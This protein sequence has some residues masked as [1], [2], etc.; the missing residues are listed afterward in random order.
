M[1]SAGVVTAQLTADDDTVIVAL[2]SEADD[3]APIVDLTV[4][5]LAAHV[6][7]RP[8]PASAASTCPGSA[9]TTTSP[10]PTCSSAPIAD[11]RRRRRRGHVRRTRRRAD[12]DDHRRGRRRRPAPFS[13]S[14]RSRTLVGG[15]GDD[16]FQ[17]NGPLTGT[18]GSTAAAATTRWPGR[19]PVNH[20][21][22]HRRRRRHDQ[23]RHDVRGSIER[24]VGGS[25]AA[26]GSSSAPPAQI[27]GSID[28]GEIQ[29]DAGGPDDVNTLDFSRRGRRRH[30]RPRGRHG[31]RWHRRV[32][33]HQ[34]ARR[35]APAPA[36]RSRA[37][38]P[39]RPDGV[40]DHAANAGHVDGVAFAGFENLTGQAATN[41]AFIFAPAAASPA[42]SPAAPAALDGFA[43]VVGADLRRL[44]AGGRRR[45]QRRRH[46]V[47]GRH[48]HLHRHGSLRPVGGDR[49]RPGRQRL[50]LRPQ[51]PRSPCRRSADADVPDAGLHHHRAAP[52]QQLHVRRADG[53]AVA[54]HRHRRR[55]DHDDARPRPTR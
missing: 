4:N 45:A 36:T 48:R 11:L 27:T 1:Y 15:A 12:L 16:S 39:A 19:T 49:R 23:R 55:R 29:L 14:S 21:G 46:L 9:A 28:G 10:S 43:V 2:D 41:D 50:D 54:G 24:L 13:A 47:R 22:R 31:R 35:P 5:G 44:P 3:G 52:G 51:T 42:R 18:S 6:R 30:R 32:H 53:L 33:Q 8:V 40:D 25:N 34:Q 37:R 20:L 7:G 17:L 38:R 26:T